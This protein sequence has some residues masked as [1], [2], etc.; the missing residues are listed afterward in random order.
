MRWRWLLTG[1]LLTLFAYA[2]CRVDWPRALTLIGRASLCLLAA[3]VCVNW[4]SLGLRGAR[5]WIFLRVVGAPSLSLAVRGAIVGSGFNNLLVANGG[6]AARALLVARTAG[7]SN[8]TIFATLVLDRLFDPLCFG[9]LLFWGSFVV[10]LP[11]SL[12]GARWVVGTALT[13]AAGMLALLARTPKRSLDIERHVGWRAQL[14]AFRRGVECLS[15]PW[16]FLGALI[17]SMGVWVLQL[18]EYAFV[19]RAVGLQLPFAG[20]I[21]AMLLINAGLVVRATPGGIGYFQFA[22]ALAVSSF[23]IPTDTAIAAAVLIQLVEILPV[24]L[25]TLLLTPTM[26]TKRERRPTH[27]GAPCY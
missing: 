6:D 13:A 20:S 2:A 8:A 7:V 10:P 14:R 26:V 23:G 1:A 12:S 27:S 19:A 4:V 3:A 18:G 9:L 22:Y 16:R 15:T 21:A 24:S 5:W 17:C 11:P 25:L